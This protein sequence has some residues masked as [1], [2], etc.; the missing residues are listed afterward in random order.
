MCREKTMNPPAE[1]SEQV[2]QYIQLY[3]KGFTLSEI[4]SRFGKGKNSIQRQLVKAGFT[5]FRKPGGVSPKKVEARNIRLN[6][7]ARLYE[8]GLNVKQAAKKLGIQP[9]KMYDVMRRS[10]YIFRTGVEARNLALKK[11]NDQ[12]CVACK[13]GLSIKEIAE[14]F[15]LSVGAIRNVLKNN[16]IKTR[17]RWDSQLKSDTAKKYWS[18]YQKGW[19][20]IRIAEQFGVDATGVS[21]LLKAYGYQIRS[22]SEARKIGFK[23]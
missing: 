23:S 12:I 5:E 10:G 11:R 13:M 7:Y 15:S 17:G 2:Q 16:E 20:T 3:Q 14:R 18:F 21:K 19:S 8:S 4:A 22:M 1:P 6:Q 9:W